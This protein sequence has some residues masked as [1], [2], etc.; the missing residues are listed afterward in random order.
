MIFNN[1][2]LTKNNII[3]DFDISNI[4]TYDLNT[5]FTLTS[6]TFWNDY[7]LSDLTLTGYGQTMYDF[8]LVSSYTDTKSFSSKD[9]YLILNR[10]GYND[11]SGNT[12]F[13]QISLTT[14]TTVGNSFTLSG[15]YL[16]S[17]FKIPQKPFQLSPYRSGIGFTIDTWLYIDQ[18]TFDKI[19]SY[20]EGFFFYF[21]TKSENKFNVFYSATTDNFPSG[22]T[23]DK[24]NYLTDIEYN[25]VGLKFND[26]KTISLRYLLNSG[27]TSEVKSTNPI[28]T[29]GWTNL[30]FT[31]K[32]CRKIITNCNGSD[33]ELIDCI[34]QRE[35]NFKIFVNGK[36]FFEKECLEE[37]FWLKQLNTDA[38]KQIGLPFTI[39]WGGGSWGLKHS[40]TP[41]NNGLMNKNLNSIIKNEF[42][43]S[44]HGRIQKLRMYDIDLDF[45]EIKKNYNYFSSKYGF[46]KLK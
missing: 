26:D 30:S 46:T 21:G 45:T 17:F 35:G 9:R 2:G 34:P 29:T 11:A 43:G 7:T 15:G 13:P 40:Y 20:T 38:D 44:F 31:F 4:K 10:I 14:S 16:T 19:T 8:G 28:N 42:D 39:N 25:A 3:F 1:T 6:L 41:S 27:I 23:Y 5:T 36:L 32:N 12:T 37:F 22:F 24:N 33:S 18:N